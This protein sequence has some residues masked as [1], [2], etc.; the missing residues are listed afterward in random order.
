[1]M[2]TRTCLLG[3]TALLVTLNGCVIVVDEGGGEVDATWSSSYSTTE[4]DSDLAR[5][6]GATLGDDPELRTEDLHVSVRRG[7]VTLK[8]EVGDLPTLEKAVSTA[9]AVDGVRRVVSKPTVEVS[10]G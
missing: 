6:V 8:G 7:V 3:L 1:M 2:T 9:A 4:A 5:R 10:S